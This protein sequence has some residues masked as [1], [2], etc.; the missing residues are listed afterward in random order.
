MTQLSIEFHLDG[1]AFGKFEQ[2][3]GRRH[4][5]MLNRA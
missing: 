3:L 4:P 1:A 5:L 2:F